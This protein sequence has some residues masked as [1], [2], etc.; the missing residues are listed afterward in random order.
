MDRKTAAIV[1]LTLTATLLAGVVVQGLR[2]APAYAQAGPRGAKL[3]GRY[4]DYVMVPMK[5]SENADVLC[6]TDNVTQRMLFFTFERGSKQL[7]VF[8]KGI[9]LTRDLGN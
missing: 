9:E 2:E 6:L 8:G 5:I 4:S 7:E 1:A 3:S